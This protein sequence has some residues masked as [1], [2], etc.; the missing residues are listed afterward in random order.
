[1]RSPRD[2]YRWLKPAWHQV[3]RPPAS[4][5]R[6]RKG[7]QSRSF[8]GRFRRLPG[9]SEAGLGWVP[10][11]PIRESTHVSWKPKPLENKPGNVRR[12][13]ARVDVC[14]VGASAAPPSFCSNDRLQQIKL[15]LSRSL[16]NSSFNQRAVGKGR[17]PAASTAHL[18]TKR[19]ALFCTSRCRQSS[20]E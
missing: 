13:C 19:T 10:G 7:S 9:L 6:Q 5:A 2:G 4:G 11:M 3:I 15:K 14:C 8:P 17:R 18:G 12:V 1:M 20:Y 16:I